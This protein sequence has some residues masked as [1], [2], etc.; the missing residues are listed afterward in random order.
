MLR[1]N[2][3]DGSA[4]KGPADSLWRAAVS[5]DMVSLSGSA[6]DPTKVRT[7]RRGRGRANAGTHTNKVVPGICPPVSSSAGPNHH[8]QVFGVVV[9]LHLPKHR[10][11]G[12]DSFHQK[13]D[14]RTYIHV[15]WGICPP[16]SS[17]S[18]INHHTQVFGVV[19]NLHLPKH[20]DAGADSLPGQS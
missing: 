16:V 7:G 15:T 14:S 3:A 5:G 4:C 13:G 18:R 2:M 17:S 11:A 8:T 12:A 1:R 6:I 20:R 9:N 19:V 10:V